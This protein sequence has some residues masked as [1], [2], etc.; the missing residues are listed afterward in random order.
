MECAKFFLKLNYFCS[1]ILAHFKL[2]NLKP[3]INNKMWRVKAFIFWAQLEAFE[4]HQHRRDRNTCMVFV[5]EKLG[6]K[7]PWQRQREKRFVFIK[8]LELQDKNKKQKNKN[9]VKLR[10]TCNMMMHRTVCFIGLKLNLF[11]LYSILSSLLLLHMINF[12]HMK[13]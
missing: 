7:H 11:N 10:D 13:C 6:F 3:S 1:Y 8:G 2:L 5:R 9:D 12:Q 4:V